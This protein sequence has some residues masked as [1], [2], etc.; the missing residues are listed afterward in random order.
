MDRYVE[1][2]ENAKE[3]MWQLIEELFPIHRT[4]VGAGFRRSLDIIKEQLNISVLSY[5][6]GKQVWDWIIPNEWNVREAYI[7]NSEGERIVD[8]QNNNLHLAAYSCSFEGKLE[9]KELVKYLCTLPNQPDAIPYRTLYYEEDEWMFCL[10]YNDFQKAFKEGIDRAYYVVIDVEEKPGFLQIGEYYLQGRKEDEIIFSTYLC[11]PSMANDNLSGVAVAVELM[12][13]LATT[14]EREYSYRLLIMPEGIGPIAYLAN[15]EDPMLLDNALSKMK[16]IKGG[17]VFTCCGDPGSLTYKRSYNGNAKVDQAAIYA[18][19]DK[20]DPYYF[21]YD[22]RDFWHHGSDEQKF[23][24]PGVRLPFGSIMRTPYAEFKEYHTSDDNLDFISKD[25]LYDTLETA[26]RILFVLD[27]NEV[28]E[29][30]Y[31]GEPFLRKHGLGY[32]VDLKKVDKSSGAY[33]RRVLLMEL[34]GYKSLL[35][36]ANKCKYRFEDLYNASRDLLKAGLVERK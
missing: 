19:K 15:T 24:G 21:K 18:I 31:R 33:M 14:K 1:V 9:Y 30:K 36:I 11:H 26:L 16:K 3:N 8:F 35:D 25:S 20:Y 4:L 7:E 34:D 27:N 6:S 23:N 17:Y 29:P 22:I 32:S 13:I 28:L 10:S 12:K 2:P 5:E